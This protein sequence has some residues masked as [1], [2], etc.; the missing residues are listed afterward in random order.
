ME[1]AGNSD[2]VKADSTLQAVETA[3]AFLAALF[4][5]SDT[6]LFRPIETWTENGTKRS[7]VDYEST[8]YRKAAPQLLKL[9]VLHLLRVA[10]EKR[11]NIFFGVC[12]RLG[13]KGRFDL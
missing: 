9:V 3:A 1:G 6:T 8:C 13:N 4:T 5:E 10:E 11:L 7:R 2:V 12:P